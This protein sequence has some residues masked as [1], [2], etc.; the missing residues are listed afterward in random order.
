MATTGIAA[1]CRLLAGLCILVT[2]LP[3]VPARAWWVR[4]WDF[5]RQQI[6]ALGS[7]AAIGL[8]ILGPTPRGW[9]AA[10]LLGLATALAWQLAM[11]LPYTRLW[12]RQGLPA[13]GGNGDRRVRLLVV[14][15]LQTNREVDGLG[16]SMAEADPDLVLALETD[17]WW[18]ER[19]AE[20]LPGHGHRLLHPLDNTYGLALFSRLE[21]VAPEIRFLLKDGIPSARTGVR[22]RSG[23]EIVL[24]GVH[25]EPPSPTEA[26]S[27][28]PR[29][30]E[31]VLLGREIA[32]E[33]TARDRRRRPQRRR[34]VAHQPAV[35]PAQRH[36][37]PARRPRL[38]QQLPRAPSLAALAARPCVLQRRLPAAR[39]A[40]P[41]GVRLGPF[42][43]PDRARVPPAR[44]GSTTARRAR[45]R[46]PS[47]GPG[48]GGGSQDGGGGL[49][50]T[51]S[52]APRS[53][54]A[55]L[56][57]MGAT[58]MASALADDEATARSA[59]AIVML[60]GAFSGAW[61]FDVFRAVLE[62][63]GWDCHAPDLIYHGADKAQGD[64][65]AG[66]S[67]T[68]YTRQMQRFLAR[69]PAPPVLLGHS[70][71]C[72]IAQ[73]LA[74]Q[75]L[76]RALILVGPAGRHGI[77]PSADF[78]QQ[79]SQGLMTLGPFWQTAVHANFEVALAT[80]LNRIPPAQQRAVFDQFGPES[81]QALF[82]LFF[83]MLDTG[84]ATAV[85]TE[86][87]RCPV[88]CVRGGDDRVVSRGTARATAAAYRG[89]ALWEPR[90]HGHMLLV[91]PGAATIARRIARWA[92]R[93]PG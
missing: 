22:L 45:P 36:D 39:A 91:E 42:P 1:A 4:A 57:A 11:I 29:D 21:L 63:Q 3:L 34:L 79:G 82:E 25:P 9:D 93:L 40:P 27:S 60:H 14:N 81:G 50:M 47:G 49:A 16:A 24:I 26:D 2:A 89:A 15:V 78:E 33:P 43:D 76:A 5:P 88:L 66:V 31:L 83:W 67:L 8:L 23:E 90:D 92:G 17:Q 74:A 19:L 68:R 77:L 55:I 59:R 38:L 75:G 64:R 69:F 35:P 87:I 37:R 56:Q 71:G 65:L 58:A 44:R 48:D 70:M 32:R 72:V 85:D 73:Q 41:A 12:R 52:F 53:R 20:L 51:G 61:S 80:S 13:K 28:L 84:R 18:V 86:A 54:R 7:L 6:T 30:A 46:G 62:E 10:L